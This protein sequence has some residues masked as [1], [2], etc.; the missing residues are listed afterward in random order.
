MEIQYCPRGLLAE[1]ESWLQRRMT[2]RRTPRIRRPRRVPA[3]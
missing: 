1:L 2:L 3:P